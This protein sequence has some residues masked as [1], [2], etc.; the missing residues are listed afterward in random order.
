MTAESSLRARP[1]IVRE[2]DGGDRRD[3]GVAA[4]GERPAHDRQAQAA[5]VLCLRAYGEKAVE[6]LTPSVDEAAEVAVGLPV[7]ERQLELGDTEARARGVDRHAH[8]AA[9]A[10]RDRKRLLARLD[11]QVA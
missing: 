11:A 10:G 8:L 3:G 6:E 2:P 4:E 1:E 5:V 9:E 7:A